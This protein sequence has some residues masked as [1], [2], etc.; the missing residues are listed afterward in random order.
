M[1][2]WW[3]IL[4]FTDWVNEQNWRRLKN[5]KEMLHL[6]PRRVGKCLSDNFMSCVVF[7]ANQQIRLSFSVSHE[8][9]L[10]PLIFNYCRELYCHC[11]PKWW[12][13]CGHNIRYFLV[14]N[15]ISYL[16]SIVNVIVLGWTYL[17]TL[18]SSVLAATPSY[19]CPSTLTLTSDSHT[20]S[21]RKAYSSFTMTFI[22]VS[23]STPTN[24]LG[25]NY[26]GLF[27][28]MSEAEPSCYG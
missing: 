19:N 8:D 3:I 21:K 13:R 18:C 10:V 24:V 16:W 20:L 2:W 23:L 6:E 1:I 9:G 15:L 5:M 22:L 28:C 7:S 14:V 11:L 25:R 26:F 17:A 4:K 27:F 12:V